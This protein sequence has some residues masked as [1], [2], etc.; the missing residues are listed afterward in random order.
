MHLVLE[1]LF[2]RSAHERTLDTAQSLITGAWES[3]LKSDD[4]YEGLIAPEELSDWYAQAESLL[5][6]YFRMEDPRQLEPTRR[7][8]PV[9]FQVADD[10]V[11]RGLVDRI[12][13]DSQGGLVLV[14]YKTG[15]APSPQYESKAMFQMRFYAL[16]IWRSTGTIASELRLMYLGDG[17]ILV[18][19][20][21][22]ADLLATQR[23]V[24]ALWNAIKTAQR[25]GEFRPRPSTLCSWCHFK[26]M[27]PAHDGQMPAFP[28]QVS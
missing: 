5:D 11:L 2:D 25:A 13:T 7:E 21:D 28:L 17:Q 20:P 24:L 12:D 23:R 22:E 1:Q 10:L 27:C 16:V 15:K 8:S 19:R 4:A 18:D 9:E 26:P 3:L 14:D 6:A